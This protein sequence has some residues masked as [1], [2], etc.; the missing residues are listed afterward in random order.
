V[1]GADALSFG[2]RL[3]LDPVRLPTN[4]FDVVEGSNKV[5]LLSAYALGAV[6]RFRLELPDAGI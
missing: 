2:L 6:V 3:D 5:G 4:L 1:F